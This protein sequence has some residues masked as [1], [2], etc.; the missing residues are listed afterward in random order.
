M[1]TWENSSHISTS[2]LQSKYQINE[3]ATSSLWPLVTN[4]YSS[5]PAFA[6]SIGHGST[7]RVNHGHE[8][9]EAKVFSGEVHLVSVESKA[10]WELIIR[11]AEVAE[12]WIRRDTGQGLSSGPKTAHR[13]LFVLIIIIIILER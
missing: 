9:N 5:A 12:T 10:L 3:S 6:H 11:Q 4:L 2:F 13:P 8:A 7:R 1:I